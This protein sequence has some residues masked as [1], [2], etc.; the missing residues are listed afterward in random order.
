M[1]KYTINQHCLISAYN[2]R[3]TAC[4]PDGGVTDSTLSA[5]VARGGDVLLDGKVY[6][7]SDLTRDNDG[8]WRVD[9]SKALPE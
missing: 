9:A 6:R 7:A 4:C 3:V 2:P 8:V 5:V 1:R